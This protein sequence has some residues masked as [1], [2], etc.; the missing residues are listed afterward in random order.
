MPAISSATEASLAGHRGPD[1]QRRHR[2]ALVTVLWIAYGYSLTFDGAG[3]FV[4]G[5]G[6]AFLSGL[7]P[8]SAV[9]TIPESVF[10]TFQMTF[11]II[12]PALTVGA[13]AE[14][15]KFGALVVF[16]VAWFTLVYVPLAHMVWGGAGALMWDRASSTS[17]AAPSCTSMPGSRA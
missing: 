6:K 3:T 11:A 8:E 4:G 15:M 12:T 10:V 9:G 7:R 13:F 16:V 5:L 1:R 2:L 17:R 14:R